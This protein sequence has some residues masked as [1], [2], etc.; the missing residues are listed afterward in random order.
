[1]SPSPLRCQLWE[2]VII[3]EMEPRGVG[4]RRTPATHGSEA[5]VPRKKL[6]QKKTELADVMNG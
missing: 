1:M 2:E 3:Q 5:P 4:E 6:G